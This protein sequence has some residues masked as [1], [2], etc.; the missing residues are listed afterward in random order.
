MT[1]SKETTMTRRPLLFV[2]GIVALAGAS[3][4]ASCGTLPMTD[5]VS[6]APVSGGRG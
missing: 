6:P 4:L 1:L 5:P 2:L 3:V